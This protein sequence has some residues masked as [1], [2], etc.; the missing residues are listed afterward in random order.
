VNAGHLSKD[1]PEF[2]KVKKEVVSIIG[3]YVVHRQVSVNSD[4][5]S[6]PASHSSIPMITIPI[7]IRL[8]V[9]DAGVDSGATINLISPATAEQFGLHKQLAEPIILHQAM[10]HKWYSTQ[11]EGYIEHLIALRVMVEFTH[12]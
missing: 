12:T 5:E 10:D 9:V 3:E 4:S 2:P 1:C 8:A 11:Q 7:K 6:D